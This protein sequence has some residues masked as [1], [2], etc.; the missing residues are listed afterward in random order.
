LSTFVQL[1]SEVGNLTPS[2]GVARDKYFTNQGYHHVLAMRRWS[3][4]E[5]FGTVTLVAGT[6]DYQVST[7]TMLD[8]DGIFDVTLVLTAAAAQVRI[9][10]CTPQMMSRVFAHCFTNS[11]PSMWTM[12]GGSAIAA[13]SAAVVAGNAPMLRLNYP[14]TAVAGSG[15]TLSCRYWRSAASIEMTA[16]A[17]LPILPVQYHNMI[18]SKALAL[19]MNRYGLA[20][21]GAAHERDFQEQLQAADVADAANRFADFEQVEMRTLPQ[22][23]NRVGHTPA[24]YNPGAVPY[25]QAQS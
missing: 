14:P 1:Y 23:D 2:T 19:A 3:F 4:L 7:G 11:Q 15:V 16:D 20:A 9:P 10:Y 22:L 12:Q 24:T 17:D 13:T 21:D 18:V 8:C 6:R 5:S 25:P